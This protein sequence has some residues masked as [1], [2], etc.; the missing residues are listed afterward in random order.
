MNDFKKYKKGTITLEIQSLIPE[1]FINLLWK[2]GIVAKNITKINITTAVLEVNLSDFHEIS[3]V[4]ERTDTRYKIIGRNGLSFFLMK[5]RGRS[6][7]LLGVVL[8][9]SV[10]Y[11]LSTFVWNIE[12]N[13][14]NYISPYEL[15]QQINGLGVRPGQRKKNIDV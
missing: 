10:I 2:K 6:A 11:Y 9:V 3:E 13:T 7:L 15:R 12:I 1:K 5:V 4:A 14:E 8:F